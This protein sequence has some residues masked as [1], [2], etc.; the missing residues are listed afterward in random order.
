[1]KF[2]IQLARL[3]KNEFSDSRIIIIDNNYKSNRQCSVP[4]NSVSTGKIKSIQCV[5]LKEVLYFWK[6]R[7]LLV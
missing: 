7:T 2:N 3:M 1:M 4:L 5:F 6:T